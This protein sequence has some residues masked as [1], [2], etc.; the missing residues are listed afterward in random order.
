[1]NKYIKNYEDILFESYGSNKLVVNLTDKIFNLINKNFGKLLL[2]KNIQIS[3]S[4]L[5]DDIEFIKDKINIQISNRDYANI[6]ITKLKV[7]NN[8]IEDLI[9]TLEFIPTNQEISAKSI[10]KTNK[11]YNNISHEL[12]HVVELYL[13]QKGK[14]NAAKS[15]KQ[16]EILNDLKIK[17]NNDKKWQEISYFIYLSLPHEQ[18]AR[19][20]QLNIEIDNLNINGSKNVVNYIKT[21]NIYKDIEFLSKI[22]SSITLDN[23]KNDINYNEILKDFSIYFLEKQN[24]FE[25]NFLIYFNKIKI[26]NKKLLRKLIKISYKFENYNTDD[27]FDR[28]IDYNEYIK[29]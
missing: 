18:R 10:L 5:Y 15:W 26:Q 25:N 1:M 13:T 8:I 4:I 9:I 11:L 17:Y 7:Y 19:I 6:N 2:N 20:Q 3:N 23:L 27:Y 29:K 24:N 21:S 16:G 14:N 22:N 12:L 28:I